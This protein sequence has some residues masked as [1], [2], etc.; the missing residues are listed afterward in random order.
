M[1]KVMMTGAAGFIGAALCERLLRIPD[2]RVV[3]LDNMNDPFSKF[4]EGAW[5][6][7]FSKKFPH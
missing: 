2:I 6:N 4:F 5:G 3:G 1:S 7:F